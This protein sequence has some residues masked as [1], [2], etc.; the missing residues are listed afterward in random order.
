MVG[1]CSGLWYTFSQKI[2]QTKPSAPV[3]TNADCQ[4]HL[5]AI[6]GTTSG[7]I[8]APIFAPELKIPVA[9]ARSLLGNH[10][11]TVLMHAGKFAASP[12][13][14]N[15]RATPNAKAEAANAW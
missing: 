14:R 12:N 15:A 4:P 2:N 3:A 13:P 9:W 7:T 8:T 11:A 5:L 10:S 1:C 6:Q